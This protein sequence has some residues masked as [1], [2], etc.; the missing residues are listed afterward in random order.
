MPVYSVS[1]PRSLNEKVVVAAQVVQKRPEDVIRK[2]LEDNI[3]RYIEEE[4]GIENK[5]EQ[6]GR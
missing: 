4:V 6:D 3:D 1:L 5:G 2:V